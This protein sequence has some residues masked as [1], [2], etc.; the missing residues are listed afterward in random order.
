MSQ[1]ILITG[2]S[3]GI[4]YEL[5]KVCARNGHDLLLVA[6][7]EE[8]LK[9]LKH[10]LEADHSIQVWTYRADLTH[11]EVRQQL[12]DFT[13]DQGL[14]LYGLVN[15]AGFGDL[16]PF[17]KAPWE[18]LN[19]MLQL[20]IVALSHLS[21]LFLPGMIARGQGRLLN[22]ASTAAFLAGPYM[23]V[24]YATKAYVLSL[25]GAIASELEETRVTA[26]T[27]CPGPTQSEFQATSDM[28]EARFIKDNIDKLPTSADVAE[29]G[30]RAM[31]KGERI[32][33]HGFTN[34]VLVFSSRL[35]P[36]KM[37][38]NTIKAMQKPA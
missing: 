3:S 19:D 6:R 18:T 10:E 22:V 26:T 35:V 27:L 16:T 29:Y 15:N 32:A 28:G 23:A 20:N 12:Y 24:Y 9:A 1:L 5:A 14:E 7:R 8:R 25:T 2:A 31:I 36:R 17:V 38:A 30:Y 4:G 33:V 11:G 37:L 21:H 34:K 13:C